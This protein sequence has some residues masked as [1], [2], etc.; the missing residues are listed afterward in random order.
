MAEMR[1]IDA[2]ISELDRARRIAVVAHKGPDGDA[3]GSSLALALMLRSLGKEVRHYARLE[4][5][6]APR[7]MDGL[8]SLSRPEAAATDPAPDL[9]VCL[10]CATVER[11]LVPYFRDNFAKFRSLVI[12][13]H[14]SNPRYGDVNFVVDDASS[15]GELVWMIAKRAGWKMDRMVAEALWVAIVTD[16]GRFSYGATHPSTLEC[17]ADL[18]RRGVRHEYLNDQIFSKEALNTALLRARAYS[19]LETWFDGA[20]AVIRLDAG[21]YEEFGCRKADSEEFV[22]IPRSV[23]GVKLA[24]FFYRSASEEKC[25]HLSI[26]ACG[27]VDACAFASLFGGG[28][29]RA[30]SGATIDCGVDEAIARV[31]ATLENFLS[32]T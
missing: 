2:A 25:T 20:V 8:D 11:I 29:H 17:G 14:E 19:T 31:R 18:L 4:D 10:D 13:H 23:R 26:R 1:G 28:G 27:G 15:T 21:D 12:D 5:I 3:I 24:I 7:V 16:T 30:A 6:G 32:T 22:N 9:L